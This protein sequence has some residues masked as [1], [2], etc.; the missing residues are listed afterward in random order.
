MTNEPRLRVGITG[1]RGFIG[2]HAVRRFAAHGHDVHAYQR[3]ATAAPGTPGV[4]VHRFEMPGAIEPREFQGLDV[5]IHAA[6]VEYGPAHRDADRINREG[7][8]RL[9]E[10]A[11]AQ[12]T[13]LI[14]LSTLSAHAAARSH[15][16]RSKLEI[17]RLFDPARD[18]ILRLGLVLGE[19]GLFGSMVEMIRGASVVPLPDGGRQPIQ[20]LWMEDLLD[21]LERV[22]TRGVAGTYDLAT[23][24]VYTMRELYETVIAGLGVKRTLVPVPLA[25]VGL[26]VATLEALRIPFGINSENVLGLRALRAFD[27]AR[28]LERLGMKPMGLKE[29]VNR[30]LPAGR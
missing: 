24:E 4:I 2:R 14:F 21:G 16:G 30:L 9:I 18:C 20:T 27:N 13:R 25:L 12:N 28:D 22:A 10:I 11:R 1:A 5:L 29:S 8:A 7:A 15:Y 23:A 3:D 17:E 26:G 6:L 19:G